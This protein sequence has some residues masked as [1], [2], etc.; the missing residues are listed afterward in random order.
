MDQLALRLNP[1][2][3]SD[4]GRWIAVDP[5]VNGQHLKDLITELE[6]DTGYEPVGG[7]DSISL[8]GLAPAAARLAGAEDDW[9]GNGEVVFLVC[10]ECREEG[11]WPLIGRVAIRAD[12]VEWSAFRQPHRPSR[13]YSAMRFAFDRREYDEELTRAFGGGEAR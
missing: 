5:I 3:E 11:C 2:N 13:D 9:P 8:E 4:R 12:T 1:H 10:A 7:Y 6:R